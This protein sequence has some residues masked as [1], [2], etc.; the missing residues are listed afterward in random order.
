MIDVLRGCGQG[1]PFDDRRAARFL[2][3]VLRF[4]PDDGECE[5]F[6][7]IVE[8][9]DDHGQ[10]L[11]WIFRGKPNYMISRLAALTVRS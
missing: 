6:R 10:S 8:W 2:D 7:Q 9:V 5:H 3:S 4:D 11:D 1:R